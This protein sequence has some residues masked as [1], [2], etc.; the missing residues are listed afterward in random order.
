MSQLRVSLIQGGI[1]MLNPYF[2]FG[3]PVFLIS[4]YFVFEC[5]RKKV[6]FHYLGFILLLISTF[7]A[8]FS[9]QILQEFWSVQSS[10][11]LSYQPD[12]LWIPLIVGGVLS[13]LNLWRGIKRLNSFRKNN[14]EKE[15]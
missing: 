13:V 2:A 11:H 12:L 15:H 8:A 14:R 5:I 1:I 10:V 4:L 7:M 3:V 9:F 6:Q